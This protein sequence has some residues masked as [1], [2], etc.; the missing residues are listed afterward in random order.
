V[1]RLRTLED[2]VSRSISQPRFYMLLL[3]L[4]ASMAMLLAAL[5]IFGVMSYAVTQRSREIGIR[6]ALGA[7]PTSVMR[8]VLGNAATLIVSGIMIGVLGS[9]ALSKSLS[10]LLFNLSPTDP[11]TLGGVGIL[12]TTVALLASYLPARQAT[13]VDPLLT[14]RSE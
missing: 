14:L 8:M 5:G 3:A 11:S 7:H 4:F 2:V 9:L 6:M 13:R 10:G 1:A 12:L